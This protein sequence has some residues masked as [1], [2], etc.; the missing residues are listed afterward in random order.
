MTRAVLDTNV[1]VSG[2]IKGHSPPGRILAALF[3][4]RFTAVSSAVLLTEVSRVLAYPKI[5]DK[6]HLAPQVSEA[7]LT[8]LALLS[9]IV[10]VPH[11]PKLTRDPQDDPLLACALHGEADFVV[12]GDS[13]ILILKEFHRIRL[14][15][16]QNFLKLLNP[17]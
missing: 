15:T 16:P 7:I 11:T 5:R 17:S 1:I 2:I 13:D 6:Y 14:V 8:S 3:K 10:S 12:S 4:G 9:D